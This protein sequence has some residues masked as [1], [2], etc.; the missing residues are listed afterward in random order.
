MRTL[1][2]FY[3]VVLRTTDELILDYC[4]GSNG[5]PAGTYGGCLVIDTS[6]SGAT[7]TDGD[8]NPYYCA[9]DHCSTTLA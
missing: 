1:V 4:K 2:H 5:S 7:G 8:G 9:W 6:G 3:I